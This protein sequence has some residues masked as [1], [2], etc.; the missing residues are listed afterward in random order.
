MTR[1][2]SHAVRLVCLVAFALLATVVP[3][4]AQIEINHEKALAGIGAGDAPGYP[5]TLGNG[6]YKLTGHLASF[7][8]GSPHPYAVILA[9]GTGVTLDLNGFSIRASDVAIQV[10]NP[11]A[12]IRNGNLGAKVGVQAREGSRVRLEGLT[13]EVFH[14]GVETSSGPEPYADL[15]VVDCRIRV[16]SDNGI[17]IMSSGNLTALRNFIDGGLKAIVVHPSKAGLVLQNF[18][19]FT[20][21]RS[22]EA[23]PLVGF[24]QNVFRVQTEET[25]VVGGANLGGNLCGDGSN[26]PTG[27]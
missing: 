6:S 26:P 4:S 1:T 21:L 27:C 5:V 2:P 24:G 22:L 18:V 10:V 25:A 12:T 15:E 9:G 13:M 7:I 20:Y 14:F 19:V 3:A 23:G 8:G 17:A 16:Q 11:V